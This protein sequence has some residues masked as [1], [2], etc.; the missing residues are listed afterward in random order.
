MTKV[1]V[2]SFGWV[3][4]VVVLDWYTKAI[5]GYHA[6]SQSTARQPPIPGGGAGKRVVPGE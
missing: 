2:Q 3:Y 5:V 6:S 1:Q 4:T